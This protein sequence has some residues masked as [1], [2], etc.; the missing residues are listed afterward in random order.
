MSTPSHV[1]PVFQEVT[2]RDPLAVYAGLQCGKNSFLLHSTRVNNKQ[3]RYSFIGFDPFLT[4]ESKGTRITVTE[5]GSPRSY[6]GDPVAEL[7]SYLRRYPVKR[8]PAFPLFHGGAVG[9]FSYDFSHRFEKLPVSTDD[10][11]EFPD[12]LFLF[13]D[14]A[15]LFDHI[16]R[17]AAVVS[18]G[19]PEN[20]PHLR[21]RR[22]QN[23]A[24]DLARQIE[25]ISP[26]LHDLPQK[27]HRTPQILSSF[28]KHQFEEIVKKA[29]DYI[30]AG[31]IFQVN[32]AQR[33]HASLS[34][35]PFTLYRLLSRINP[36]PF[37]SFFDLGNWHI[38]SC[39][40][41]RL[42]RLEE[43]E[44]DTRPIAGTR[45]RGREENTDQQLS[46]ELLLNEKE[47]AE[48]VMLVD[49]ERNDLGRVC[50][51]GSV[52]V[53]ELMV[54]EEYSHVFHIVSNVRGMLREGL[55]ALDVVRACFPGG[56]IT[57]TPK[58]RSMEI[59][60]ELE[61]TRRGLYTGSVG[62]LSFTGDMDLNIVIRTFVIRDGVAYFHVGG[63]IV[64]DS[65][66]ER[67]YFETLYKAQALLSTLVY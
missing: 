65:D 52:H 41:E 66:P 29:K 49:L 45:P 15:I 47:Q 67:E 39:S 57:G 64:A 32:L 8:N 54:L 63:G 50:E 17:K 42:V 59:I 16:N 2:Y 55:D 9:C 34:V 61:T 3:G 19:Y 36:S 12:S 24:T 22:A 46:K 26:I 27:Q 10:D 33:L 23:K 30:R 28:H 56:T 37:A 40:P 13:V 44:V 6:D 7:R 60:D 53:N 20:D 18:T 62:Y 21:K 38:V 1:N 31:D 25:A 14:S 11:L 58:I 4:F 43:R 51:Y 48:H 35:D 5:N